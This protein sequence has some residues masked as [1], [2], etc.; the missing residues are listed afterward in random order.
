MRHDAS[1]TRRAPDARAICKL[2]AHARTRHASTPAHGHARE[3]TRSRALEDSTLDGAGCHT[4]E[5]PCCIQ[6]RAQ[7][8]TVRRRSCVRVRW[9]TTGCCLRVLAP[10]DGMHRRTFCFRFLFALISCGAFGELA[11]YLVL[12]LASS[13]LALVIITR[14]HTVVERS[15]CGRELGRA[16]CDFAWAGACA[17]CRV[18]SN[19]GQAW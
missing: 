13:R 16:A 15:N 6:A 4:P 19:C 5:L 10:C 9:R 11:A 8:S 18:L 2:V 14:V 7:M 12:S 3:H 1:A 17:T